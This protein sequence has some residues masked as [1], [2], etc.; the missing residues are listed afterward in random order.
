MC[1]WCFYCLDHYQVWT[2]A[3]TFVEKRSNGK[4][5]LKQQLGHLY[6]SSNLVVKTRPLI[7]LLIEHAESQEQKITYACSKK[8]KKMG[9]EDRTCLI[10]ILRCQCHWYQVES[11]PKCYTCLIDTMIVYA[12]LIPPSN[13]EIWAVD[14]DPLD[15]L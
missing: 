8:K 14:F 9:G 3:A 6:H 4:R 10:N 15:I 12:Y 2:L 5:N 1:F 13:A 11:D 7:V